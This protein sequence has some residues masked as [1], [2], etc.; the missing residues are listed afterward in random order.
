L[1]FTLSRFS[2]KF[3]LNIPVT[4]GEQN[5]KSSP[6]ASQLFAEKGVDAVF[7]GPDFITGWLNV[8]L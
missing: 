3:S 6:L 5:V 1:L 8:H 2:R 4:G 7:F